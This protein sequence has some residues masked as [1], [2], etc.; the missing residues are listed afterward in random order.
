M[1]F[2]DLDVVRCPFQG[3]RRTF[4]TLLASSVEGNEEVGAATFDTKR[5]DRVVGKYYGTHTETVGS[6]GS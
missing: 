6:N 5:D 1:A 3:Y 2:H 4:D